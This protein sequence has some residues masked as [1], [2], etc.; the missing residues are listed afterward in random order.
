LGAR[1]IVGSV[2]MNH[3]L[4]ANTP[5]EFA[6]LINAIYENPT[7]FDHIK[8]NARDFILQQFSWKSYGDSLKAIIEA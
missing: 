2:P 7:D 8:T 5:I 1:P 6:S 4:I 3:F